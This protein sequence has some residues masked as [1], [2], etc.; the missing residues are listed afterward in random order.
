[1][2]PNQVS[3][4]RGYLIPTLFQHQILVDPWQT[5]QKTK[6]HFCGTLWSIKILA[7][8]LL[9]WVQPHD[10]W[11]GTYRCAISVYYS[12]GV[13]TL[14]YCDKHRFSQLTTWQLD[15]FTQLKAQC[16]FPMLRSRDFRTS[17]LYTSLAGT[18]RTF[19]IMLISGDRVWI[20]PVYLSLHL[21]K[22]KQ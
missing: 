6:S 5:L 16:V 4:T 13:A 19:F 1:M 12:E 7:Y 20:R 15:Q 18:R 10:S 17:T 14:E 2:K 11:V 3:T 9:R 22:I 21:T 8:H